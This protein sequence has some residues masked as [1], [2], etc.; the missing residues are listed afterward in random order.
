M[1]VVS[2]NDQ[3]LK[4][5]ANRLVAMSPEPPPFPEEEVALSHPLSRPPRPVLVAVGAAVLVLLGAAIPLIL[6]NADPQAPIG[7]QPPPATVPSTIGST[8][9]ATST[10]PQQSTTV[11]QQNLNIHQTA[12]FGVQ[13]PQNSFLSNPAL[14]PFWTEIA[15]PAGVPIELLRLQ[16]LSNEMLTFP[17]PSVYNA[18]PS[19]VEF[20]DATLNGVVLIIDV[21][22]AF[23]SG[24]GGLL[25]DM[26]MLNQ[27]VYTATYL[28]EANQVL[29][30]IDGEPITDFGTDGLDISDGV[31][32]ETFR[33]ALNL[34]LV[35]QPVDIG[36]GLPQVEGIA[37]VYEATV[38]MEI[39]SPDG[40][41]VFSDFTTATC[42][43]G[44][45]GE[46]IFSLD[47][48]SLE[49]GSTIRVFWN[50]PEDGSQ[51]DV[52]EVPFGEQAVWDLLEEG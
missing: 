21:N 48:P 34:V 9:P 52:V 40:D 43:T 35:T 24:A 3:Q 46:Y 4:D 6:M 29:F 36:D 39:V 14:I 8:L 51:K 22:E 31:T 50:S 13:N 5:L 15:G 41:V 1:A 23:R 28:S 26:T 20:I 45:W 30:R 42:G 44:C 12:V 27:I 38:S 16:L 11:P 10:V 19:G 47:I 32:T 2:D 25:S 17:D 33:D 49:P 37:N 7:S 18:V